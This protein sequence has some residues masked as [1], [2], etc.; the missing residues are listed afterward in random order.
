MFLS[1]SSNVSRSRGIDLS[2]AFRLIPTYPNAT[3]L[4]VFGPPAD[5]PTITRRVQHFF[6]PIVVSVRMSSRMSLLASSRYR[7]ERTDQ[8]QVQRSP[9]SPGCD[10]VLFESHRQTE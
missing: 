9:V 2:S 4:F 3:L 10:E 6:N 5:W 7:A 8:G 1:A